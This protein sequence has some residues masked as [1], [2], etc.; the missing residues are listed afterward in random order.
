MKR[1]PRVFVSARSHSQN[2]A[3]KTHTD[4]VLLCATARTADIIFSLTN[5]VCQSHGKKKSQLS[6]GQILAFA[7]ETLFFFVFCLAILLLL[8]RR[9][10]LW[11]TCKA[12]HALK[13]GKNKLKQINCT[14][15]L[16][17]NEGLVDRVLKKKRQCELKG[18]RDMAVYL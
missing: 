10:R 1:R 9:S 2:S 8:Q 7:L 11:A 15:E 13:M 5:R 17:H 4:N 12:N 3:V 16:K 14:A 6:F 18:F